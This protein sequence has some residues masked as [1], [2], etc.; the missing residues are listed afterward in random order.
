MALPMAPA[1]WAA[2][3]S[4]SRDATD[5]LKFPRRCIRVGRVPP[6]PPAGIGAAAPRGR[7]GTPQ[8]SECSL[9]HYAVSECS[10]T[11]MRRGSAERID[12]GASSAPR[13]A[14]PEPAH[15]PGRFPRGPARARHRTRGRESPR[16]RRRIA[17]AARPGAGCV[18]TPW[19]AG[20]TGDDRP[21]RPVERTSRVGRGAQGALTGAPR[22]PPRGARF[23]RPGPRAP[24][25]AC[26][27]CTRL[28]SASAGPPRRRTDLDGVPRVAGA[29]L[30]RP[31]SATPEGWRLPAS[32][33]ILARQSVRRRIARGP[34]RACEQACRGRSRR[35]RCGC[36]RR[37]GRTGW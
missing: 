32:R 3:S 36:D 35:V 6:P 5:E 34:E 14:T 17:E 8:I 29:C 4:E 20:R 24:Q 21:I 31:C 26:Q 16:G 30:P 18:G 22:P 25:R 23:R 37:G 28:C 1:A 7:A 13:P 11:T 15:Q 33:C 27:A 12:G 10:L 2:P 19:A 9:D